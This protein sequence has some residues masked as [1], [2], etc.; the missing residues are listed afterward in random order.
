MEEQR[1]T[2]QRTRK[3]VLRTQRKN[4]NSREYM[5]FQVEGIS[6]QSSKRLGF[7][8]YRIQRGEDL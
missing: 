2:Q 1:D 8:G 4:M 3:S 5:D 7:K 6:R